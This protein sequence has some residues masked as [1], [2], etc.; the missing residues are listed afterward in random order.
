MKEFLKKN[1]VIIIAFALPIALII[2]IALS[3]YFPSLFVST[4]YDFIYSSCTDGSNYYA[5][6]CDSY[7]KKRYSIVNNKLVVNDVDPM[8]DL[9]GDNVPD[10]KENYTSRIFLHDTKKNESRE[11]TLSEAQSLEINELLTSP[12]GVTVSSSYS[13]GADYIFPFGGGN[14]SFGYYLAKGRGKS[15]LNLINS[16]ERYYYRD[17]FQFIGWVSPGRSN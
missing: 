3:A 13:S 8:Q 5:Y 7:L 1:L 11:I 2:V 10:I 9:D 12:D 6:Q 15:K 16:D 17:N 14:S 4:S